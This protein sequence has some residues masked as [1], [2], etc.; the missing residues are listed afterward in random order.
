MSKNNLKI[1][2]EKEVTSSPLKGKIKGS[3][4]RFENPPPPPPKKTTAGGKSG[5]K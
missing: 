4:P 5:G 3:M 2:P 1:S